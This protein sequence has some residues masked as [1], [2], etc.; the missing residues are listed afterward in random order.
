M[1]ALGCAYLGVLFSRLA[2]AV[3][4]AETMD[5]LGE[6]AAGKWGKRAVYAVF[7]TSVLADP[8]ALHITCLL[9]LQQV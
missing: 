2:V 6:A 8:V 5:Q 1:L 3:P 4:T 9:A 7:Y